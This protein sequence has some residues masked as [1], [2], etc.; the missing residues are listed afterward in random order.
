MQRRSSGIRIDFEILATDWKSAEAIKE[1]LVI[2][3]INKMFKSNGIPDATVVKEASIQEYN[4]Q[5]LSDSG[6]ASVR[7]RPG[8]LTSV[9]LAA[10][11]IRPVT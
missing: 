5:I 7:L 6:A 9:F 10:L 4:K 3:N 8:L 1:R 2:D 11:L